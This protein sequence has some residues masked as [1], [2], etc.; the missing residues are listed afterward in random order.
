MVIVIARTNIK[1]TDKI[2]ELPHRLAFDQFLPKE[3]IGCEMGVREGRHALSLMKN[4]RPKELHLIDF[5]SHQINRGQPQWAKFKEEVTNAFQG[6]PKVF[7]YDNDFTRIMPAFPDNYFDWVYID[8]WHGYN[9]IKRDIT[10]A[11]PKIKAGG[12]LCG[13]DFTTEPSG[14]QT[15]VIRAVIETIQEGHGKMIA[16]SNARYSDWMIEKSPNKIL[17]L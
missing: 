9:S 8:G 14:W 1:M 5:W 13:H 11:L 12:I 17:L 15:G 7:V 4:S 3:G 10:L 16:I 6:N 2:L